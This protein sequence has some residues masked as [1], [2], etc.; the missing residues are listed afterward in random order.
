MKEQNNEELKFESKTISGY[1]LGLTETQKLKI[2]EEG[3]QSGTS[4][5]P[6]KNILNEPENWTGENWRWFLINFNIE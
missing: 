4:K 3:I 6:E 1:L 2:V 5:K